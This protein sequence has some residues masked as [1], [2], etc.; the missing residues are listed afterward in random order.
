MAIGWFGQYFS[1]EAGP[2]QILH[3]EIRPLTTGDLRNFFRDAITL[4]HPLGY[5]SIKLPTDALPANSSDALHAVNDTSKVT[6]APPA[7][8]TITDRY[9]CR[10]VTEYPSPHIA[11]KHRQVSNNAD[12]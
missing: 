3:V 9:A 1:A 5:G 4:S 12:L 6:K 11:P 2:P 10:F 7:A 8:Q